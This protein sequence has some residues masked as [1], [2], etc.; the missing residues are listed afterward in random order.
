MNCP[1]CGQK[2]S[3]K[4]QFYVSDCWQKAVGRHKGYAFRDIELTE[5]EKKVMKTAH[6]YYATLPHQKRRT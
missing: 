3:H 5:K 1:I 4:K 2:H 6:N